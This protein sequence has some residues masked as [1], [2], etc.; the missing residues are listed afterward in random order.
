MLSGFFVN[1]VSSF[2]E[3]RGHIQ[4]VRT[5]YP[6]L[7]FIL[8]D[9]QS[10]T[11]ADELCRFLHQF[12]GDPFKDTKVIHLYTPTTDSL[13]GQSTFA[14]NAPGVVRMTKPPRTARL[15]QTLAILKHPDQKQVLKVGISGQA[16]EAKALEAR[17]LFGNV[18]IA[19]GILWSSCLDS[20]F[21]DIHGQTIPLPRGSLSSSWRD[22]T[23][24][25]SLHRMGRKLYQV[26]LSL[27]GV[28]TEI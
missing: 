17:T 2:E 14:S 12:P 8:L 6:P 7:D 23:S 15:L 19:E 9:E 27:P 24:M 21:A 28:Q 22:T 10:E 1:A 26:R 3:A 25:S 18:L 4:E 16:D 5:T 20:A 11:R 13:T